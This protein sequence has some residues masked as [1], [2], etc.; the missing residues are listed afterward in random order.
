MT[1]GAALAAGGIPPWMAARETWSYLED[2]DLPAYAPPT[3]DQLPAL[4]AE[5]FGAVDLD[6]LADELAPRRTTRTPAGRRR[7]PRTSR[8]VRTA[9]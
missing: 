1:A 3:A 5:R 9:A 7:W 2:E 4:S 8:P 6:A